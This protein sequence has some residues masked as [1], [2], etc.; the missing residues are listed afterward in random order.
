[1]AFAL[2]NFAQSTTS[3]N[4]PVTTLADSS[5]IG[6]PRFF[7]YFTAD[8]LATVATSAY[9]NSIA[10]TLAI[11]DLIYAKCSDAPKLYVVTAVSPNV[12]V[13]ALV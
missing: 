6:A 1:M 13:T 11:G 10:T 3:L 12:T 5:V 9:F 7:T 4:G 2:Q 8:A